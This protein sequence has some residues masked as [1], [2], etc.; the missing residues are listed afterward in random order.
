[1]IGE[2]GDWMEAVG[3]AERTQELYTY[4]LWKLLSRPFTRGR[5]L[6][7]L[8]PSEITAHLAAFKGKAHSKAMHRK[9]LRC[10][11]KWA[12]RC[13]YLDRDPTAILQGAKPPHRT[14]QEPFS[15]EE[16]TRLLIAAAWRSPRRAWAIL[17]C[18]ALGCRRTEFVMLRREDIDF[19]RRLVHLRVTK[20]DRPR[21]VDIGPL[22]ECALREL[23][24]LERPN[25]YGTILGVR[26]NQLTEW[27][28][29]AARDCG[30]PEGRKRRAH[31]LRA[32]FVTNLGRRGV[33]LAVIQELVGHA[34][35]TT[36]SAY[37]GVLQGETAQAVAVL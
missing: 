29:R 21:D 22:A 17:A 1:L 5:N 27:V 14:R 24:A 33:P 8:G 32:T 16:L 12:T 10:F 11:Y 4:A 18:Y 23:L 9:A 13:G 3:M 28:N 19:E 37:F 30:F 15:Q 2:W 36:T 6:L 35:A 20:G 25:P 31:T 26:P 7:E 34:N